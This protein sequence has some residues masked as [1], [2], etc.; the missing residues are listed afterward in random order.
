ML[1]KC[2]SLVDREY[3][4]TGTDPKVG[5]SAGLLSPRA[6]GHMCGPVPE[7]PQVSSFVEENE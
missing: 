4:A 7:K 2:L 6:W 3:R 1:W 5:T